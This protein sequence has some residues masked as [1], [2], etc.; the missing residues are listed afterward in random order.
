MTSIRNRPAGIGFPQPEKSALLRKTCTARIEAVAMK[1][2]L[3]NMWHDVAGVVP[4]EWS[5]ITVVIVFGIVSG[6]AA[7]RDVIIDELGDLSEAVIS[8][9]QSFS[10]AGI[11]AL[12]IPGSQ[13][14]DP[15]GTVAD[16]SRQ[17]VGS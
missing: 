12:G 9:D 13:F 6:L 16:C 17:P 3:R 14:T 7:A 15:A 2:R 1:Q 8:W 11:P 10:F 4:F 5:I